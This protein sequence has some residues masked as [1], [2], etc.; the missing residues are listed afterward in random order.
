MRGKFAGSCIALLLLGGCASYKPTATPVEQVTDKELVFNAEGYGAKVEPYLDKARQQQYFNADFT[1]A[2]FLVVDVVVKNEG[3]DPVEVRPYDIYL[4]FPG[5]SQMAPMEGK[6]VATQIEEN[7]S[8]VGSVLMF[9]LVGGIVATQ[10]EHDA[11]NA[12]ILDYGAKELKET[13]LAPGASAQGYLFY[14]WTPSASA[15][16][17]FVL[18]LQ[19]R[20][21]NQLTE[22]TVPYENTKVFAVP[23]NALFVASPP[24]A[25]PA[26][27]QG[28]T[29]TASAG[30]QAQGSPTTPAAQTGPVDV[31]F[32]IDYGVGVVEGTA[33]L[34]DGHLAG[35]SSLGG[36]PITISGTLKDRK[37][38]IDVNGAIISPGLAMTG[39]GIGY[40]CSGSA[41]LDNAVGDVTIALPAA[42]GT[43]NIRD[44]VYLELPPANPSASTGAVQAASIGTQGTPAA[45]P[46]SGPIDVPFKIDYGY[47]VA[48]GV[49]KL[50]NGQLVGLASNGGRSIT[51][52]AT[53]K[54]RKLSIEAYGALVS[55]GQ[56][57]SGAGYYC[58][59]SAELDGA[60]GSVALPLLATCGPKNFLDTVYLELPAT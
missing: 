6:V 50:E 22:V 38:S 16:A 49:A 28:T 10:A 58:S 7:G 20:T 41:E 34:Q 33:Q 5:G 8:V 18:Q 29:Q 27:S 1:K 60:A 40:Y 12:R 17:E 35:Q 14:R 11:K 51:L 59:G 31:P 48:E 47:G 9:G 25:T 52:K 42:C 23:Q 36:R 45:A 2:G 3:K 15:Q 39:S 46:A 19:D 56:A 30:N 57:A 43:E 24:P 54:D 53:L 26:V 13:T 37:L 32:K 55:N 44:T 4:V 21:S